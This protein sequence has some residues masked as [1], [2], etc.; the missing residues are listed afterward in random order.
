MDTLEP[1]R[2]EVR[3]VTQ[4]EVSRV[5]V[6]RR[7]LDVLAPFFG[8]PRSV[9]EAAEVSGRPL[10]YVFQKVRR[11][12]ALELL[13]ETHRV[14]RRGRAVRLYRVT[15]ESFFIPSSALP[16]ELILSRTEALYQRWLVD[17][18]MAAWLRS[19]DGSTGEPQGLGVWVAPVPGG[20]VSIYGGFGDGTPWPAQGGVPLTRWS[21]LKLPPEE[22]VALVSELSALLGRYRERQTAEGSEYL[23]RLAVVRDLGVI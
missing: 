5:L 22:A 20:H 7:N 23:V 17:N 9:G 16:V 10:K 14:P 13:V 3:E 8:A 21:R 6:D 11:F 18:L 19:E 4:L 1:V 2:A 15:A 12:V